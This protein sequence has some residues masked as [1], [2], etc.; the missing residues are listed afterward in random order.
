LVVVYPAFVPNVSSSPTMGTN[1]TLAS[2]SGPPS[3]V[4]PE[5]DEA[6][7]LPPLL[8][9]APDVPDDDVDEPLAAPSVSVVGGGM[10]LPPSLPH[11]AAAR[12][13]TNALKK[14]KPAKRSRS[15]IDHRI[16]R[17]SPRCG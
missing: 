11:A 17:P 2:A 12:A 5:L 16:I 3:F 4:P 14:T 15:M 6:P 9:E 10:S 8:E 13:P 1:G 7:L